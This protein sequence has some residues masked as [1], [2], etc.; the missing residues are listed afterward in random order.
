MTEV[1]CMYRAEKVAFVCN[2]TEEHVG[3]LLDEM[4]AA[5][6]GSV[7]GNVLVTARAGAGKT[8]V[9]TAH[10]LFLQKHCGVPADRIMLLA[11]N[12]RAA[13]E[14]ESRL[15]DWLGDDIPHVMTF[16]ALAYALVHPPQKL[17]F[18]DKDEGKQHLSEVTQKVIDEHVRHP[19]LANRI[20]DLMLE[21][22][23]ADWS[24]ITTGGYHLS[25]QEFLDY[26]YSLQ[27]ET[28][29]GDRVSNFGQKAIAN[30][31][32]EHD[33][34]YWFERT[35]R[36][37]GRRLRADFAVPRGAQPNLY[38]RFADSAHEDDNA[39]WQQLTAAVETGKFKGALLQYGPNDLTTLGEAGFAQRLCD[40][41]REHGLK[42]RRLSTDELWRA[43]SDRA[44][45]SFTQAMVNFVGRCRQRAWSIE[46]L[47]QHAT[48]RKMNGDVS[49]YEIEFYR[50]GRYVY[51]GYLARLERDNREDFNGLMLRAAEKVQDGTT[52]FERKGNAGDLRDIDYLHIDEYQDFSR[53]FH[54]L[55][56][57]MRVTNPDMT[58]FAVGDDWQAINGFAGSDLAYFR[59][60]GEHFSPAR[61]LSITQNYRSSRRIVEASNALLTDEDEP[62]Q[63]VNEDDGLVRVCNL[64]KF[65]P[66]PLERE[67]LRARKH[68]N[69][70]ETDEHEIAVAR[71]AQWLA[72]TGEVALLNRTRDPDALLGSTLK[73]A[74]AALRELVADGLYDNI[75]VDTAHSYKGLESDSVVILDAVANHYPLIHPHWIF[76][77]I[78]GDTL[79][80][81]EAAELRLFYVAVSRARQ[82]L[83]ICTQHAKRS[84]FFDMIQK[85][86]GFSELDINVLAPITRDT[87]DHCEV[88]VFD[89]YSVKDQL[90]LDEF[91]FVDHA[92][93]SHKH[94]SRVMPREEV[95]E[96]WITKAPWNNGLVRIEVYDH[97]NNPIWS[98]GERHNATKLSQTDPFQRAD[99]LA[100]TNK[101]YTTSSTA[102]PEQW[103]L[104]GSVDRDLSAV[105]TAVHHARSGRDVR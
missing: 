78:F 67:I 103:T 15:R 31:L 17:L 100:I 5:A 51:A 54:D 23:R 58:V 70:P 97:R 42:P 1:T 18:D 98:S 89:S 32:A 77:Q 85:A 41:L 101:A 13:S 14:M 64:D 86:N 46:D 92:D 73:A 91:N 63:A 48:H 9:L 105:P 43:V 96:D 45:D 33:V 69:G 29:R 39:A 60:F 11:F 87:S 7:D 49:N 27:H 21:H 19:D 35:I 88:R 82:R 83:I 75:S 72:Q 99:S 3:M 37:G 12:R 38:I 6:V 66:T 84:P 57:A 47:V 65:G 53:S 68:R 25:E 16:H 20:Q 94:W 30:L 80:S 55:T 62:A 10:A 52:R 24:R 2:W 95:T 104:S 61:K 90:K 93:S 28:L 22:F 81:V 56:S 4:Q 44:I 26:R 8:R 36:W 76:G 59:N 40:D 74:Q 79:A 50:I 71:I 34:S 102:D